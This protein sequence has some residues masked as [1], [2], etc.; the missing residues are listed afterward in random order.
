MPVSTPDEDRARRRGALYAIHR[1][2]TGVWTRAVVCVS[3]VLLVAAKV[4]Y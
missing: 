3:A 1:T 4:L 2:K